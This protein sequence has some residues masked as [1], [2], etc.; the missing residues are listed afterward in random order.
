MQ[1]Q[2]FERGLRDAIGAHGAWKMKL[3]TTIKFGHS[4][5][6]PDEIRDAAACAFGQWLNSSAMDANIRA[7][8][9]YQVV[10]RLHREF[11]ECAANVAQHA[12]DGD[13]NGAT[14]LL[15]N[16]FKDRSDTLKRALMK[17]D[18]EI[19]RGV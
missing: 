1:K 6:S 14:A 4:E 7:G 17:W 10:S 16:E 11:H 3:S 5:K 8:K 2:E 18:G 9:P 15:E 19:R 13:P 12:V